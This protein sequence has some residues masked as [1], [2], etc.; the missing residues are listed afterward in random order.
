MTARLSDTMLAALI[1]KH[2]NGPQVIS[3]CPDCGNKYGRTLVRC[4]DMVLPVGPYPYAGSKC[5]KHSEVQS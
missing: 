5:L 1:A 3:Y 2:G 4:G